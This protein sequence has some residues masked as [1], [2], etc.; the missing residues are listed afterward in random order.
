MAKF[1]GHELVLGQINLSVRVSVL[2]ALWLLNTGSDRAAG[3]LLALAVVLKPY[4]V[5]FFPWLAALRRWRALS[6]A[7]VAMA[8]ALMRCRSSST[9]FVAPGRFIWTGG[10]PLP[11]STAPNLLNADNVSIAAM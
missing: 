11:S 4:A 5:L 1:Y 6:A 10:G 8:V 9:A 3:A 7:A 2:G